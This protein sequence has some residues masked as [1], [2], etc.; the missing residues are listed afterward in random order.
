[1]PNGKNLSQ[2]PP[3]AHAKRCF[4]RSHSCLGW[5]IAADRK[6][7]HVESGS[8]MGAR[9]GRASDAV[10]RVGT[11]AAAWGLIATNAVGWG[12]VVSVC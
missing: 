1:M 11:G 4:P 7:P 6:D 9:A 2:L 5:Q 8:L 3:P 12:E 10:G